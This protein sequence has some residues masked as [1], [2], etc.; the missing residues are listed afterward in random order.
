MRISFWLSAILHLLLWWFGLTSLPSNW[1]TPSKQGLFLISFPICVP[2]GW[3][4]VRDVVGIQSILVKWTNEWEG[5]LFTQKMVT[6]TI[7]WDSFLNAEC[8][9]LLFRKR[10]S[11][12]RESSPSPRLWFFVSSLECLDVRGPPKG[13]IRLWAH[14]SVVNY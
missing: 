1:K 8:Y 3:S 11:V 9:I 7:F 10:G 12:F 2:H 6:C 4:N 5:W 14:S 13:T